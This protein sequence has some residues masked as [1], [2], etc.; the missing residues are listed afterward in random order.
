MMPILR[1]LG[2]FRARDCCKAG[3]IHLHYPIV[4][5]K[6]AMPTRSAKVETNVQVAG[7]TLWVELEDRQQTITCEHGMLSCLQE[8]SPQNQAGVLPS[9][10]STTQSLAATLHP[11]AQL[12]AVD[13][14]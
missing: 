5:H 3:L 14:L 9:L 8:T 2:I 13:H 1:R 11:R 10:L 7:F 4:V 12:F 6:D